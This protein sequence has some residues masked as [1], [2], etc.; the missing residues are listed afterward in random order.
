MEQHITVEQLNE[1]SEGGRGRLLDWL[2]EK[3]YLIVATNKP[4]LMTKEAQ[5]EHFDSVGYELTIGQMIEFLGKD[6]AEGGV[7]NIEYTG[8]GWTVHI[9]KPWRVLHKMWTGKELRDALWKATKEMLEN[10]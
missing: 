4:E 2:F 1:L 10:D 9:E 8:H 6:S 3:G 7:S 5:M